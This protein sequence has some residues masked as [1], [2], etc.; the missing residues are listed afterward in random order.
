VLLPV[1]WR[2]IDKMSTPQ[3]QV[4]GRSAW[5]RSLGRPWPAGGPGV[6]VRSESA[7]REDVQRH[8]YRAGWRIVTPLISGS[9]DPSACHSITKN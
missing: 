8:R 2:A 4:D 6:I 1:G 5:D 7:L 9:R 3:L